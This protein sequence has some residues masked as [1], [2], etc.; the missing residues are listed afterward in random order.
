MTDEIVRSKVVFHFRGGFGPNSDYRLNIA[1]SETVD[2]WVR[3]YALLPAGAEVLLMEQDGLGE[4]L[5]SGR[6]LLGVLASK[7]RPTLCGPEEKATLWPAPAH[8]WALSGEP[9]RSWPPAPAAARAPGPSPCSRI[10][11]ARL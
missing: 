5:A 8:M 1:V 7:V 4:I 3:V 6:A 2:E 10:T 11:R 9:Y